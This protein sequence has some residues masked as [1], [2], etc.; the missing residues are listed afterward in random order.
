MEAA[1]RALQRGESLS[2]D[3]APSGQDDGGNEGARHEAPA[4]SSER[5]DGEVDKSSEGEPKEP[6][7]PKASQWASLN[8]RE[9]ELVRKTQELNK[10]KAE[11]ESASAALRKGKTSTWEALKA[12]GFED[13]N[14]FLQH[15]AETGGEPTPEQVEIQ[16]LKAWK[17]K[18]E[19]AAQ[20]AAKQAAEE[21]KAQEYRES[22]AGWHSHIAQYIKDSEPLRDSL[23]A[24]EGNEAKVFQVIQDH[25][26][27]EGEQLDF[28][29]AA[30]QVNEKLE[31]EFTEAL[32]KIAQNSRGRAIIEELATKSLP[33]AKRGKLATAQPKGLSSSV[34]TL[35][36][37]DPRPDL[38][39]D[40]AVNQNAAWLQAQV[41]RHR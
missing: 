35:T 12:L 14:E 21:K 37:P 33:V 34:R 7:V 25:Y 5:P 11:L 2:G 39:L 27:R 31:K 28:G 3:E 30:T 17:A 36:A 22:V 10:Q 15:L 8:R 13:K 6:P 40:E 18:Q 38:S 29:V 1:V 32:S 9:Q 23:V 19:Q 41:R 16:E 4:S 26:Q 20:E 24:L